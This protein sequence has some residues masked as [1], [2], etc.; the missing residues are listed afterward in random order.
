MVAAG[1][2]Q[3]DEV[4]AVDDLSSFHLV[5]LATLSD[6]SR[7]VVKQGRPTSE[8]SES[9]RS[10]GQELFVYRLSSWLPGLAGCV[11]EAYLIDERRQLLVIKAAAP[12]YRLLSR[13]SWPSRAIGEALGRT[14]AGWHSAT[15][16]M[17]MLAR[18]SNGVLD[19]VD[20]DES[21]WQLADPQA[22]RLARSFLDDGDLARLLERAKR[23]WTEQCLVHGDLK[24]DNCLVDDSNVTAGIEVIDWELSGMGDPA[25]DLACA[26]AESYALAAAYGEDTSRLGLGAADGCIGLLTGYGEARK[27]GWPDGWFAKLSDF[28]AARLLQL[29]LER[30]EFFGEEG[31]VSAAKLVSVA[32]QLSIEP[33][34]FA[35]EMAGWS[36][37]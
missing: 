33:D 1:L 35:G 12:G 18:A 7:Y 26:L 30:M 10:L 4:V 2:A 25:W 34:R 6:G 22:R 23:A 3:V 21:Q 17:S 13:R 15:W 29:S 37:S 11:P 32:R 36:A 8:P 19:L 24:W 5:Q 20:A 27:D 9:G 14:I 28:V 16:G 31:E